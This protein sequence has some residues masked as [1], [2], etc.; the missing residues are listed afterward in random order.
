MADIPADETRIGTSADDTIQTGG[1][2]DQIFASAGDDTVQ[3]GGG[4]DYVEGGAGQDTLVGDAA[5]KQSFAPRNFRMT[6]DH[7]LTLALTNETSNT[8][9]AIGVYR[10][11][12][13]T[14]E[15]SD[16]EVVW[17]NASL[18]GSGGD[19]QSGEDS[20]SMPVSEGDELGFFMIA[21]GFGL[22]D[23]SQ[24]Q[25]GSFQFLTMEGALGNTNSQSPLV[26]KFV[27]DSGTVRDVNGPVYHATATGANATINPDGEEHASGVANGDGSLEITFDDGTE[28]GGEVSFTIDAGA[29]NTAFIM[30]EHNIEYNGGEGDDR[31]EGRAGEDVITGH[32]GDDLLVGGGASVEWELIDGKWVYFAER[33]SDTVDPNMTAD[34]SDDVIIG[35]AG[36]DVLLGNA[37]D[38]SLYA[39]SGEDRINGGTGHDMAFGDLGADLI[40]LE[41]GDD[42]AEGGLG[43]DTI[44]A[45]DGD[46]LVYGDDKLENILNSNP[47]ASGFSSYSA[48]GLWEK[49]SDPETGRP[50]ISQTIETQ[51]DTAYT[52]TIDVAAN[53][54]A[55]VTQG[56]VEVIWNGQVIDTI[57]SNSGTFESHS[58]TIDGTGEPGQLALRNIEV[59]ENAPASSEPEINT[60]NPIFSYDKTVTIGDESVKIDAFAPGQAKLYQVISGQLKVFDPATNEYLDAGAP[61]AVKVNAIGFNVEDD[62]I[63]GIAKSNG[64]DALGNPISSKDLVMMDATGEVYRVGETP[65]GDFVGDFDDQGNLW[66]FQSSI[67]RITKI[68]VDNLDAEG[69]PVV[70][71]YYLPKDFLQGNVYD[72]AFNAEDKSFYAVK[73]P[74]KNGEDGTLHKI[75][76]SNFD[77][78]GSPA[79]SELSISGTLFEDSMLNGMPKGAF[80]AVFL[81]GDGNLFAGLNNGDH[82]L[83]GSTASQGGIFQIHYDFEGGQAYA[84]FKA[85]SE[86]TGSND[87]AVDPRSIDPFAVVEQDATVQIRNLELVAAEGGDDDLRGGAGDDEIYGNAGDDQVFGGT[88]DDTLS[89]DEGADRVF[90]GEGKDQISGGSGNDYLQGDAGNDRIDGGDGEDFIK[91]GIGDDTIDGGDGGDSIYA[92]L[93][94]DVVDGGE[95]NDRVFAG[96]GNDDVFGNVGNDTIDLGVGDDKGF[97]GAGD[98]FIQGKDGDDLL[99]GGAGND[100]IVGGSGS[101]VIS[102]GAGN[103]NIWG[104]QWSGDGASDTFSFSHGGGRDT[105][106][107]FEVN[108]DQI[109]L[110]AYG[111]SYDDLQDRI[112]DRGWATEINLEGIDKSGAGDKIM[113]RSVDP[114][115]LDETNFIL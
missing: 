47:D 3:S 38:D 26:L 100:K 93:G 61:A 94:N 27:D 85:E 49:R 114:D 74:S 7:G 6:E 62:L 73:A 88:G 96:E 66:T 44:N 109:D 54:P 4:D 28:A 102:G 33:V 25:N 36:E 69:N 46:D 40:N 77:G 59:N 18:L 99:D 106:H 45:G 91:G 15:I 107:D 104:G 111:F 39:G 23:F 42:Y 50:E 56:S 67:N 95:G 20:A 29:A 101:D 31:L 64:E 58:I 17:E 80:G 37:G 113:L 43:A 90:G 97:G 14:G 68:D 51:A 24:F 52:F 83:D 32:S 2:A 71:N 16:V 87:G 9:N 55:G 57:T 60:D 41:Q 115:E 76:V 10:I 112:I 63:Y 110:S 92:E 21:D 34:G 72:I 30:H 86:R 75:D 79:V 8:Q 35:G 108:K 11:D 103:D 13:E 5:D 82:D 98:D 70:E 89:G 84:E 1:G 65:V 78:N 81:D 22:N 19:M 105:I 48:D 12:P 53:L